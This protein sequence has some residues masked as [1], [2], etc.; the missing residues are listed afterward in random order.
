M[1]MPLEGVL[2]GLVN[3]IEAFSP[4][5]GGQINVDDLIEHSKLLAY[6]SNKLYILK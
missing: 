4:P 5:P 6:F 3:Y 2:V 1:L